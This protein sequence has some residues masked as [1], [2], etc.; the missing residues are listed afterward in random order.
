VSSSKSKI[1]ADCKASLICLS[2]DPGVLRCSRCGKTVC[3]TDHYLNDQ[4]WV[5]ESVEY[6]IPGDCPRLK[7][8]KSH[9]SSLCITCFELVL[10][11]LGSPSGHKEFEEDSNDNE[12]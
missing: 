10:G 12:T 6:P 5:E 9:P 11:T 2:G 1:C 3:H 4:P 8:E 7:Q